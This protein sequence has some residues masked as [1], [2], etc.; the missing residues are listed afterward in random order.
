AASRA[1]DVTEQILAFS[2]RRERQHH[3]LRVQPVIAEAVDLLRASFPATLSVE[4]HLAAADAAMTGDPTELQQVVMNLGTNAAQ[5]MNSRGVL[6]IALDMTEI[7]EAQ[8]LSHGNLP[9]GRYIRL[10][11]RDTGSG[12]DQATLERIFEP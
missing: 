5:A 12:M 8:A 11:V 2:R 9:A 1:Q 7:V 3:A 10:A 4:T 6:E